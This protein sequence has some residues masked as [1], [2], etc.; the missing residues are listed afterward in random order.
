MFRFTGRTRKKRGKKAKN[1][2]KRS[3]EPGKWNEQA[4]LMENS[5]KIITGRGTAVQTLER[6]Q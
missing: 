5:K 1:G 6:E 3:F 2:T 4:S